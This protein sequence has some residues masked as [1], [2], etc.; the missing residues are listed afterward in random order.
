MPARTLDNALEVAPVKGNK[1]FVLQAIDNTSFEERPIQ[2][3]KALEVQV[4][5]RQTGICGS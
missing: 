4:N 1:S 5:V 2:P 3:P